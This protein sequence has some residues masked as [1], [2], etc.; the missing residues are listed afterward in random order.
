[1]CCDKCNCG[2]KINAGKEYLYGYTFRN[3]TNI[4]EVITITHT[5]D[6]DH[7]EYICSYGNYYDDTYSTQEIAQL[8]C[9]I[10]NLKMSL[11]NI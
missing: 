1:M 2:K 8:K 11:K 4:Y 10:L 5:W 6:G 3:P 9:D 7:H